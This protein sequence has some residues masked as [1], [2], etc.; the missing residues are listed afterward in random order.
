MSNHKTR[1][2]R[3]NSLQRMLELER[4]YMVR[5]AFVLRLWIKVDQRLLDGRRQ[6]NALPPFNQI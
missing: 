1:P 6:A 2:A 5:G 4:R 3:S